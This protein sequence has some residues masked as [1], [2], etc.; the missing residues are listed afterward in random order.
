MPGPAGYWLCMALGSSPGASARQLQG[1]TGI[2]CPQVLGSRRAE[3]VL[4]ALNCRQG[5]AFPPTAD[6]SA[7]C[8]VSLVP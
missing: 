1:L 6:W 7:A 8:E 3:E 2:T 4:P 5:Q